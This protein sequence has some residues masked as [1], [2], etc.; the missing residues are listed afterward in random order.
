MA[1]KKYLSKGLKEWGGLDVDICR[2]RILDRENNKHTG[3]NM[4]Q[5]EFLSKYDIFL[6]LPK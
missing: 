5:I 4:H 6:V 3:L 1:E 2:K